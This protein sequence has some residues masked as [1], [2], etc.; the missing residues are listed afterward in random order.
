MKYIEAEREKAI[1]IRD[2]MF[3]DPGNGV[4]FG[5]EREFVLLEPEL[6][7]WEGVREDAKEYFLKNKIPWWSGKDEPTGHLLSSQVA[8][9][10]HLYPV[11]TRK[12]CCDAILKN[13]DSDISQ[14]LNVDNGFIEFEKTGKKPL[15]KEKSI[16]RGANSTSIDAL[17]LG[18]NQNEE[19][20][21]VLIEWKYT[22]SYYPTSILVS[23]S[24]TNRLDVYKELLENPDCPIITNDLQGL[25]YEPYYQ[26]MRQNLL[27]WTM[28]NRKEYGTVDWIHIHIIPNEN[29]E[30]REKITSP[31]LIG[32]T[33]EESWKNQ[34]RHPDKYI[35]IS[36]EEFLE[37][38]KDLEDTSSVIKYLEARY[39]RHNV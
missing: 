39:W 11:R 4:F 26:L 3:R 38:I 27:G 22:E 10:N 21:L 8:C 20:I 29:K 18:Q 36:P 30:L 13:I 9:V 2:K 15:G 31:N 24:G 16:Q 37:P 17:M 34:L 12:D 6:N 28:T 25:F 7:L 19:K 35:V 1:K 33:L 5:K 14:A 32:K 23:D